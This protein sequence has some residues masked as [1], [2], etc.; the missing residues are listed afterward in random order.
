[1]NHHDE[2]VDHDEDGDENDDPGDEDDDP[3]DDDDDALGEAPP[4]V[5]QTTIT[6]GNTEYLRR[7]F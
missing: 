7:W 2:D 5:N 4:H 6:I 1:M 3:G